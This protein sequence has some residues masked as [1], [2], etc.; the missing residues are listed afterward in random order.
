MR[1]IGVNLHT[2]QQSIAMLDTVGHGSL[3]GG[4]DAVRRWESSGEHQRCPAPEW[5][6]IQSLPKA[7]EKNPAIRFPTIDE[8][9]SIWR[10]TFAFFIDNKEA[11][12]VKFYPISTEIS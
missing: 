9:T 6:E 4:S 10:P 2:R 7:S 12:R 11:K 8:K 3:L 1:I 5:Q